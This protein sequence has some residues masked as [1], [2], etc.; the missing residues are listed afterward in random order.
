MLNHE[1]YYRKL[2]QKQEHPKSSKRSFGDCTSSS[3]ELSATPANLPNNCIFPQDTPGD[4]EIKTAASISRLDAIEAVYYPSRKN[5]QGE[6]VPHIN[7]K[8]VSFAYPT[9]PSKP[10]FQGF[11]LSIRCGEVVALV[12]PSGGG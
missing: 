2:V 9:R 11:D 12:G 6:D 3:N 7:F 8:S 10:I 4:V 1:G 5:R